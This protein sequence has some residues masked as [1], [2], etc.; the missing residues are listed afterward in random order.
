LT[1]SSTRATT[2]PLS[3]CW[4][5]ACDSSENILLLHNRRAAAGPKTL[6]CTSESNCT[7]RRCRTHEWTARTAD[8][9]ISLA[10]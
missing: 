9:I 7:R 1:T 4:L 3:R 6:A 10:Q 2:W 8:F 5:E